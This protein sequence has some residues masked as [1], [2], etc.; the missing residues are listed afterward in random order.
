MEVGG[1]VHAG[2]NGISIR[3]APG[4]HPSPVEGVCV[5]ELSS[6]IAGEEFSDRP[7]CVCPVIGAYLR[8]WNDRAPHAERQQL[9]PYAVRIVGS[10]AGKAATRRRR[11][12]CLE[13]AGADL[14]RGPIGRS[15]SRLGIRARIALFCGL[16]AALKLN[17]GAGDYAARV[18]FA[19]RDTAGAFELLDA[20]LAGVQRQP[21]I[22]G[23]GGGRLNGDGGKPARRGAL[24]PMTDP[25][26]NGGAPRSQNGSRPEEAAGGDGQDPERRTAPF[27]SA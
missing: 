27:R 20:L 5:V 13:W 2:L 18:M 22:G 1:D 12:T 3:L 6:V 11:D 17:E 26:R 9:L 23:N 15:V 4:S 14:S 7:R 21:G 8:S 24:P 10:R 16:G 25:A 19:R